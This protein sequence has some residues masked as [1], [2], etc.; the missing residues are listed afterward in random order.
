MATGKNVM[1]TKFV[2]D[3]LTF[4]FL[5]IHVDIVIVSCNVRGDDEKRSGYRDIEH[6]NWSTT[7]CRDV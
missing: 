4:L 2:L 1:G 7:R 6:T 3:I 5:H